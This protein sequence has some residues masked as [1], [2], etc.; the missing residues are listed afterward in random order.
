MALL[1]VDQVVHPGMDQPALDH[2]SFSLS[3]SAKLAIVGETGSGKTTL[4]KVIGGI[5]DAQSGA[6][7]LNNQKVKGPSEQLL[8]G[9]PEIGYISQY[10]ELRNHYKVEEELEAAN[11]LSSEEFDVIVEV[12]RIQSLLKR[13]TKALSGG[14]RQRIV[15]AKVLLA[16]PT[17][18]LLDEPFSNMDFFHKRIMKQVLEEVYLTLGTTT[19]LVTHDATDI[20][21]WASEVLV[22]R[23]GKVIQQ[24]KPQD[25]YYH[26]A[27]E[28]VAGLFGEYCILPSPINKRPIL[29]RPEQLKISSAAVGAW[30]G[31]VYSVK[32]A[33]GYFLIE[34]LLD[35]DK[36]AIVMHPHGRFR[37]G[38]IVYI[39]INEDIGWYV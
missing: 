39:A 34:V 20:F 21:T 30:K 17:L 14:E 24:G 6:V 11:K 36:R 12:C 33:G 10:F 16:K 32:F 31:S 28:Y 8:P 4:L 29:F 37:Q 2:V 3:K 38:E 1:K 5:L 35:I 23:S 27:S 13:N 26:P 7:Y 18:L 9:H 15:L 22:L 25:I 19:I